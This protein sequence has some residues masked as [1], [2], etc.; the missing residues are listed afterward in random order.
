MYLRSSW[1]VLKKQ[2]RPFLINGNW[3][4]HTALIL[5]RRLD[6]SAMRKLRKS[7]CGS[8]G[9]G[10]WNLD[11]CLSAICFG[12][13]QLFLRKTRRPQNWSLIFFGKKTFLSQ[14]KIVEDFV[15]KSY[16]NNDKPW[17]SL[18]TSRH[19]SFFIFFIFL[20]FPKKTFSFFFIF[21]FL[22]HLG[23]IKSFVHLRTQLL[24]CCNRL[25]SAWCDWM[26]QS[27][28]K[29]QNDRVLCRR[30]LCKQIAKKLAGARDLIFRKFVEGIP[31]VTTKKLRKSARQNSVQIETAY[32]F[33][34][35]RAKLFT[36]DH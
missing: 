2:P 20:H 26:P 3:N 31:H 9:H 21:A 22:R 8:T 6:N 23:P 27:F 29:V 12:Y 15:E 34:E 33:T 13:V 24:G 18:R 35:S 32:I 4:L 30:S 25:T 14:E 17:K 1:S 5:V 19:F 7:R 11:N 28:L 16:N 36:I 10:T